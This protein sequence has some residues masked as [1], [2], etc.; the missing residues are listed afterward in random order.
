MAQ[1]RQR[2]SEFIARGAEVVVIGPEKAETFARH[3]H[4]QDYPFVGLPDPEHKVAD[5]YGQEVNMLKLG[6]LPTLIVVDRDGRVRYQHH[7]GSMRD[8][9]DSR[10]ILSLLDK[11]NREGQDSGQ[12]AGQKAG[13]RAEIE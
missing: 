12:E 7:G 11:L 2:Y 10:E 5:L 6:R 13:Q 4:R 9:P 1:L 8:I 3:W